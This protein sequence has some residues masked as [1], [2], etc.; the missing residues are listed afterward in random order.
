MSEVS[1]S[2]KTIFKLYQT[3]F[4]NVE[5]NI[6]YFKLNCYPIKVKI[7]RMSDLIKN[8]QK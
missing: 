7:K 2:I 8:Y 6:N 1:I 5:K 3:F 4:L